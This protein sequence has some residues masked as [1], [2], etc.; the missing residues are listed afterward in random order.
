MI[1]QP[2]KVYL[3][4]SAHR[5][6]KKSSAQKVKRFSIP[7]DELQHPWLRIL[8]DAYYVIDRGILKSIETEQDKGRKLACAMGCSHC[9]RTHQD[10]PV[11]PLELIGISWYAAEKMKGPQRA[12]LRKQLYEFK[13]LQQCPFLME[14]ICSIHPMRPMAC[15]QFNVFGTPCAEGEDPFHTRREDVMDPVKKYVDQAFFIMMQY[16]GVEK[17]SE[18]VKIVESGGMHKM[19]RELHACNW[20]L[21]AERMESADQKKM[22]NTKFQSSN[23]K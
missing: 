4:M 12:S 5:K 3:R 15:R 2:D 17:D 6:K 19:A 13:K 21:L 20:Q 8:L 22:T 23:N 7:D 9:C 16:H 10:I 14:E 1:Y 18:R 11:Y